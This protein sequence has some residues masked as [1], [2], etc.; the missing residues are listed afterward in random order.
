[1]KEW[2]RGCSKLDRIE[3]RVPGVRRHRGCWPAR[4][5]LARPPE[6]RGRRQEGRAPARE[7]D[8]EWE[9]AGTLGPGQRRGSRMK[10]E[11]GRLVDLIKTPLATVGRDWAVFFIGRV[12]P[13]AQRS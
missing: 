13:L 7:E 3:L 12:Q 10:E 1:V 9:S 6:R 2:S 5:V 8:R 4:E 11:E